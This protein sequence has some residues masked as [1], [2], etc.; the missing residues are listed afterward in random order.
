MYNDF[1][2]GKHRLFT[3]TKHCDVTEITCQQYR[4]YAKHNLHVLVTVTV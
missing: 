1:S 4:R 3:P 2:Q